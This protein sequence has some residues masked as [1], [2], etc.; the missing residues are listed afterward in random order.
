M[1]WQFSFPVPS[2]KINNSW[3]LRPRNHECGAASGGD[4]YAPIDRS[5]RGQVNRK[6]ALEL[7]GIKQSQ[8]VATRRWMIGPAPSLFLNSARKK[9]Y[10]LNDC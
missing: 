1:R 4:E 9:R 3:D 5:K 10:V 2:K 8:V 6:G 7:D